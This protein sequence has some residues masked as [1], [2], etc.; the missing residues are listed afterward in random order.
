MTIQ[1]QQVTR[2][3]TVG[4]WVA[5]TSSY[6]EDGTVRYLKP[7]CPLQQTETR[8]E[9]RQEGIL[10]LTRQSVDNVKKKRHGYIA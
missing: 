3:N 10:I 6:D 2:A 1:M 4:G 8:E 9:M 5:A 7:I